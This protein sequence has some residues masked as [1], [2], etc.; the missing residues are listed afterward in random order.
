[1]FSH[2]HLVGQRHRDLI[3]TAETDSPA[4]SA[5]SVRHG[6]ACDAPRISGYGQPF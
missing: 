6:R 2:P 1:M 4:P 3:A 5:T